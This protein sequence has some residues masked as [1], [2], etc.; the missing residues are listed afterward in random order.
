MAQSVLRFRWVSTLSIV[1]A[2]VFVATALWAHELIPSVADLSVENGEVRLEIDLNAEALLSGI[3]QSLHDD[4]T[5]APAAPEYDRLR[6]LPPEDISTLFIDAWPDLSAGLTLRADGAPLAPRLGVVVAP[7]AG[8]TTLPRTT[9][10]R[11][12]APLPADAE[13]LVIGWDGAYGAL[14][15]RQQ[16]VEAPYS[17]YLT[18]GDLSDPFPIAGGGVASN[19]QTFMSYIIIGFEHIIPKGLDHI[20]FVLGLFF[21]STRWRPLIWQ[22]TAFTLAHTVTLALATLGIVNVPGSIVEPLIA[23]SI[24]YV[25]IENIFANGR[26]RWRLPIVFGFGLLH[27][28]GFA[29]V[30]GDIGLDPAIFVTGLIGFNVGVELGQLAVILVAYLAVGMWFGQK[31]WYRPFVAIPISLV[32]SAIGAWWLIERTLL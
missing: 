27:G 23:A 18:N 16:G 31:P 28:L 26:S 12:S 32:I 6:A 15:V 19:S 24:V 9:R 17:G 7:Q 10:V 13:T 22:V 14:V 29:S 25:G 3:D 11:L 20:L 30:L 21:F 5:G 8:D 4:S 1:I 2:T